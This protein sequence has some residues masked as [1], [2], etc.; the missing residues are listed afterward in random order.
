ML[1]Y[2]QMIEPPEDRSKFEII[3]EE[4]RDM[5]YWK[6]NKV[7]RNTMD[8]EDA[9]HQAFVRVAENIKKISDP[10]CPQTRSYIVIILEHCA[11]DIYRRKKNHPNIVLIPE[12]V[13]IDVEYNGSNELAKCMAKLKPRERHILL[14]RHYHGYSLKE[15]AEILKLTYSNVKKIDQRATKKLEELCERAHI[16]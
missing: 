12:A 7:L 10:M 5:M 1:I 16:L 14:L 15:I 11:I 9:V 3:Y 13:G 8:A 4:Y 2:L 6:A